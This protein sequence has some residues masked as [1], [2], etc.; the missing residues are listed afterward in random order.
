MADQCKWDTVV[1]SH[2]V[3][4]SG[5]GDLL[6]RVRGVRSK[7]PEFASRQLL[8]EDPDFE[9]ISLPEHD[10]DVLR[11]QI[12]AENARTV[13]EI[14]L[15][16]GSSAL[17]IGEAL[18]STG[19]QDASHLIIDAYQRHFKSVGWEAIV[20]A[21]LDTICRLV[22]ERSQTALPRLVTEGFVA[23]VAFVD[24]SH[25]F[26]NVFVD[27]YFLRDLVRPGG[28]VILDDCQWP[29]VGT[30]VNYYVVNGGWIAEPVKEPTRL[31]AFR[32]PE[33]PCNPNFE[34]FRPFQI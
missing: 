17:A 1:G 32:L 15:A 13:V 2:T 16:Y 6:E 11:N 10:S 23:D 22:N 5:E 4:V 18:V 8:P 29:S 25:A 7:L 34:S 20:S 21:G 27:L 30:A 33:P 3:T 12:L 28:L 31:R 14:G 19:S 26:Q 9:T 24:G